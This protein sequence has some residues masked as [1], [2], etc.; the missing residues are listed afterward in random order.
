L[1]KVYV[2]LPAYNAEL[3]LLR[4]IEE[5]PAGIVDQF[6]LVDD[7]SPDNTVAL[8]R[9][10]GLRVIVHP[11][12]RGYGANQKTCYSEAL[13]DGADVIVLL[14]PDYQYDPK[15]VPL[16]I[17]PIL[18]GY[19]DMSFGSRFAATGDPILGGMPL[20]RYVGN[21]LATT[22]EN[23]LLGS[24]FTEMHSGMRAYTRECLLSLPFLSYSDDFVFDSQLLVDAVTS[25]LRITEVPIRTRYTK[26]SSS[27]DI[28][29]S[30][31]Y[32]AGSIAMAAKRGVQRGRR[33]RRTPVSLRTRRRPRIL[34]RGPH[35]E[36]TCMLCGRNDMYL[37]YPSNTRLRPESS[38]FAC[39]AE[40]VGKHDDILQCR[41]CGMVSSRTPLEDAEIIERYQ[42]TV[43]PHYLEEESAR[44]ELFEHVL[45]TMRGF[46]AHGRSLVEIG[47]HVGLFLD[48]AAKAGWDVRGIEPSRWAVEE[49]QR[50]F[51]VDL[52][53]GVAEEFT[54]PPGSVDAVVM[55]D[56]L[57]HLVDPLSVLGRLHPVLSDEG[58]MVLSTVDVTSLHAR[59]RRAE[60]PW[61]IFPHLHYYTPQTLHS[62]LASAGYRMVG[63]ET[64]PRRFHLSSIANRLGDS[65]DPVGPIA[66]RLSSV[67]DPRVPVGWLGDIV[68]AVARKA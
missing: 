24:R 16:L 6:L 3:T 37:L 33:G 62:T 35:T 5:I 40:S 61:F 59:M 10:L 19:A 66:R 55:L 68:L 17:A 65:F 42:D 4:T 56:V 67:V 36:A 12:N 30:M 9:E 64:V 27:I 48:S 51:G 1:S 44:R 41:V 57:E 29:R 20:Y 47:S 52:T 7:A 18:A 43:D 8:A 38:D 32:V 54:A 15:A 21:R 31:R 11:E 14:H 22:V 45:A 26:E 50:R 49:G 2:T 63:W 13:A 60:W 53:Q 28:S 46:Y 39:T 25:G 34:G 58:L 23:L